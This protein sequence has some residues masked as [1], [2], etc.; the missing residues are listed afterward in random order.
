MDHLRDTESVEIQI[1]GA[2]ALID[3]RWQGY[4]SE[5]LVYNRH[6]FKAKR[7]GGIGISSRPTSVLAR[8]PDGR[9]FFPAGLVA[10]I[11]AIL[12]AGGHSVTVM[13]HTPNIESPA[14][15]PRVQEVMAEH[16]QFAEAVIGTLR[17]QIVVCNDQQR[18]WVCSQICR[19]HRSS[20]VLIVAPHR[21]AVSDLF[22]TVGFPL[23]HQIGRITGRSKFRELAFRCVIAT[24]QSGC[25]YDGSRFEVIVFPYPEILCGKSV[26]RPALLNNARRVYGIIRAGQKL[27]LRSQLVIEGVCGGVIFEAPD[28]RGR[29]PAVRVV[30][31]E[32][33][34]VSN[35][36]TAAPRQRMLDAVMR[37]E[38][39]TQLVAD[40]ARATIEQNMTR[41]WEIGVPYSDTL[42][43]ALQ[44]AVPRVVVVAADPEHARALQRRLGGW[45][46]YTS[47]PGRNAVPKKPADRP[48]SFITTLVAAHAVRRLDCDVLIWACGCSS[49][50]ALPGFPARRRHDDLRD[51]HLIDFTDAWDLKSSQRSK[52]RLQSYTAAAWTIA[53]G[54]VASC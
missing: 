10:R 8:L 41:L 14:G 13:D 47:E 42:G 7:R 29:T 40:I 17:G 45:P 2:I 25:L 28:P 12:R 6:A 3:G 23:A 34:L 36:A 54:C 4:L 52:D 16:P 11:V 20:R 37:N 22:D 44:Q 33:P 38:R 43:A 53:N 30:T 39:R 35:V 15:D 48:G 31:I 9:W 49:P 1:N 27:S 18:D 51:I 46:L 5:R 50:R 21:Q 32:S 24:Y 19:L 26:F